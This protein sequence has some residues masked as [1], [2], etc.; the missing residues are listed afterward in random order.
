MDFVW[1]A[2]IAAMW[3]VMAEL[4]VGLYKLDAPKGERS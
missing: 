3:V 4:V 2:A 1:I